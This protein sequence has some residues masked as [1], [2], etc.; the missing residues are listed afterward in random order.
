M[1]TNTE[2]QD[3]NKTTKKSAT[4]DLQNLV[5]RDIFSR[6]GI[7]GKGVYYTLNPAYKGDIRGHTVDP[8]ITGLCAGLPHCQALLTYMKSTGHVI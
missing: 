6:K 4:R 1:I 2:Y 5:K 8:A 3:I 7:T